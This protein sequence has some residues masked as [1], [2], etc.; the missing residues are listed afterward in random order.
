M[1]HPFPGPEHL[2]PAPEPCYGSHLCHRKVFYILLFVSDDNKDINNYSECGYPSLF[3]S[4]IRFL[5]GTKER[6]RRG[7]TARQRD[8]AFFFGLFIFKKE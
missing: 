1:S 6:R 3:L 7:H 5:R 8:R 4:M 2:F